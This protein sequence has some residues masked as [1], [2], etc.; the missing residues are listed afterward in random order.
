MAVF[1]DAHILQL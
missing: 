1:N